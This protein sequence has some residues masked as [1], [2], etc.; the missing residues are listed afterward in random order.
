MKLNFLFDYEKQYLFDR[1]GTL[2]SDL[3]KY[4]WDTDES[5][6]Y[7]LEWLKDESGTI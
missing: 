4:V 2:N 1:R 7:V 6:R 3:A 5:S